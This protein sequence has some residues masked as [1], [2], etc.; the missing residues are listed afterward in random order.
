MRTCCPRLSR[1][2]KDL[3]HPSNGQTWA[4]GTTGS[5]RNARPEVE[6]PTLIMGMDATHMAFQVLSTY[7]TLAT[8]RYNTNESPASCVVI[9][10]WCRGQ[11]T[12]PLCQTAAT[13]LIAFRWP[14]FR[15]EG[16]SR[17][18]R[19]NKGNLPPAALFVQVGNRYGNGNRL[20]LSFLDHVATFSV[21]TDRV[22]PVVLKIRLLTALCFPPCLAN[23]SNNSQRKGCTSRRFFSLDLAGSASPCNRRN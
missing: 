11:I 20:V 4:T 2:L 13:I 12:L 9:S 15:L 5:V 7:K 21:N 1:R 18:R 22:K 6:G 16:C 19:R 14:F 3:S 23:L 17:S 8:A 10:D